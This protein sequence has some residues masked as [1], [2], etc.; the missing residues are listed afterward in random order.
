AHG[1]QVLG[2][3]IQPV[4]P[5]TL[6]L[7]SPKQRY[8]SLYRAMGDEW[9]WYAVTASDQLQV[10]IARPELV[11]MLNFGNLVTPVII[12]LCANSPVY[13]GSLSPYCSAREGRMAAIHASEHRHG[14]P[15]RPYTSLADYVATAA[16]SVHLILQSDG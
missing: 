8:Q 7:M 10:D 14:M 13:A 1:Y 6:R 15:A 5:P 11:H 4:T 9:L 16:Q 12:A 2:Y 3:G